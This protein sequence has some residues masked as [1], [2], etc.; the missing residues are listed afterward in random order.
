MKLNQDQLY[1]CVIC[2]K[3]SSQLIQ[4]NNMETVKGHFHKDIKYPDSF[5]CNECHPEIQETIS[6]YY[7]YDLKNKPIFNYEF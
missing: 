1:R 4:T 5:T 3:T 2:N 6:D 7:I